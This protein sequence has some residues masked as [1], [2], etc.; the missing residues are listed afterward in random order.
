MAELVTFIAGASYGAVTVI[1]G[2]PLDT[3][4]V[5]M[6]GLP[7]ASKLSGLQVANDLFL[8]E[9]IV[10]LYRGGLPLFIGGS[11]MRS[12]QFGVSGSCKSLLEA[13]CGGKTKDKDRIF[14]ALLD[15]Q[16]IVSGIA[17]GLGRGLVE[18]P[19]SFYSSM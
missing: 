12:A 14:F 7:S 13:Y 6:Q 1:V 19:V 11:L 2:Q 8:R 16:V 10:G 17:G 4:K 18:A 5:R 3:V 9:G 15:W